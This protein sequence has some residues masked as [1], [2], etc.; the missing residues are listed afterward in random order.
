MSPFLY[1]VTHLQDYDNQVYKMLTLFLHVKSIPSHLAFED[2]LTNP[3]SL[4]IS[5]PN[6]GGTVLRRLLIKSLNILIKNKERRW[7]LKLIKVTQNL[8]NV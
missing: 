8:Y 4:P 1:I 7:S 6:S 2:L 5:K 3:Y